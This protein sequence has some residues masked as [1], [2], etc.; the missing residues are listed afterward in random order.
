MKVTVIDT[1]LD[2]V[3]NDFENV[4]AIVETKGR[5]TILFGEINNQREHTYHKGDKRFK[6]EIKSF[7]N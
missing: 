5:V 1:I 3:D 2:K 4:R 6:F 7:Y